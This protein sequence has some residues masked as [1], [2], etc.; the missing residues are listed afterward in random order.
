MR[1]MQLGDHLMQS[2]L[3]GL[4]D[5]NKISKEKLE[6]VESKFGRTGGVDEALPIVLYDGD[7]TMEI[8][9]YNPKTVLCVFV[10]WGVMNES[11]L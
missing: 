2:N 4:H 7:A 3:S 10:L 9:R 5:A 1:G 6:M 8:C 11:S